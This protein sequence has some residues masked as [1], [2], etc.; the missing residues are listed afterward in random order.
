MSVPKTIL[1][2]RT[3]LVNKRIIVLTHEDGSVSLIT[4]R[5]IS[6][7]AAEGLD[8]YTRDHKFL[9]AAGCVVYR[10]IGINVM[11]SSIRLQQ[12]TLHLLLNTLNHSLIFGPA[13]IERRKNETY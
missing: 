13:E 4:K 3:K 7:Y 5:L 6:D 12:D 10:R 1:A 9:G 11:V 2:T 8:V